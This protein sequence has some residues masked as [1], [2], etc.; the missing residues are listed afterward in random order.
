M[1]IG[2]LA[3]SVVAG[4]RL[5]RAQTAQTARTAEAQLKAA[6]HQEQVDGDLTGAIAAYKKIAQGSDR[7]IAATALLRLAECYEKLGDAEATKVYEQLVRDFG[8]QPEAAEARTRLATLQGSSAP[9]G[10]MVSRQV[11]SGPKADTSGTISPD[12]RYISYVDWNTGGIALHDLRTGKDS[13]LESDHPAAGTGYQEF[14]NESAISKDGQLVAYTWWSSQDLRFELRLANTTGDPHPRRLYDNPGVDWIAPYDWSP[15]GKSVVVELNRTD[16]TGQI[17]FVSVPDGSLRVLRSVDSRGGTGRIFFSPDGK[18]LG[19]DLAV[20]DTGRERDV[21]VLTADG[22]REVRVVAHPSLNFMMGWSPDGTWLLFASDRTGLMALWGLPFADGKPLGAP[23]LIRSDIGWPESMGMTQ[24]GGFYYGTTSRQSEGLNI[25]IASYDAG[26]GRISG[27]QDV[28]PQDQRESNSQPSWSPDGN[29]LAYLS[30]RGRLGSSSAQQGLRNIS[31][32]IRSADAGR[33]VRQVALNLSEG[34]RLLCWTP[35][36]HALLVEGYGL[37]QRLRGTFRIDAQTGDVSP[38]APNLSGRSAPDGKS[39]YI[40]RTLSGASGF[41]LIQ[42]DLTSGIEKELIRRTSLDR[43][44]TVSPDGQYIATTSVTS[45]NLATMLVVPT[46]GGEP[47]EMMPVTKGQ[48]PF[49]FSGW[50]ADSRSLLARRRLAGAQSDEVWRVPLT[51]DEPRKL[52]GM[53]DSHFA[54]LAVHPDGRRI[55]YTV[56]DRPATAL[57]FV[58]WLPA[59]LDHPDLAEVWV[60]EHF[61]PAAKG[62]R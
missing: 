33:L 22:T 14:A 36:G 23:E 59:G 47:R 20:S 21:R 50:A 18:Y 40:R 43:N 17:G 54:D 62:K 26:T 28:V 11:W 37:N 4:P 15:D 60:L 19:Y 24:S 31:L 29:Y 44:L 30:Q 9:S 7:A 27:A 46:A 57:G 38:I 52:D 39:L 48:A 5:L 49:L 10:G 3:L 55:A 34:V 41:A 35:D 61:L 56:M 8:T 58:S 45:A 12:G 1:A 25:Q 53:V 16:G 32:V 42:R 13:D 6:E 2:A 51:G